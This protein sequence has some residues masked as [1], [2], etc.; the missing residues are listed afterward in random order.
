M[1]ALFIKR[2]SE[3]AVI[4]KRGSAGA[5]GYDLSAAKDCLIPARGKALVDTDLEMAVPTGHYGRIGTARFPTAP[6]L[7]ASDAAPDAGAWQ[8]PDRAWRGSTLSTWEPVSSM[9]TT[10][11]T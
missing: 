3:H 6:T 5:A 1:A 9:P 4:P 2:L 8:R 11:G 10:A 7:R